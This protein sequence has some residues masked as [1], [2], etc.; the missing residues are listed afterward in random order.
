MDI[1]KEET[2]MPAVRK[3]LMQ[4]ERSYPAHTDPTVQLNGPTTL[5]SDVLAATVDLLARNFTSSIDI[6]RWNMVHG[7]QFNML[8]AADNSGYFG[9]VD[10]KVGIIAFG[11]EQ[12]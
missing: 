3:A 8:K 5:V 2:I 12:V 10:T 6:Q 7:T 11:T 1:N 9:M 4:V